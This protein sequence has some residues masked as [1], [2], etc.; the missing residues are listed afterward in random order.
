MRS[1][2]E[3][4]PRES[5]FGPTE[6]PGD[7]PD[8]RA[9]AGAQASTAQAA[10]LQPKLKAERIQNRLAAHPGWQ[11]DDGGE[12]LRR[13]FSFPSPRAAALFATL[14]IEVGEAT[15]ELPRIE[16]DHLDVTLHVRSSAGGVTERDFQLAR[17]FG[18]A[19]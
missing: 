3:S 14:A 5:R 17:R 6:W 12:G 10:S 11:V 9:V 16:I 7:G 13:R 4:I 15:G 8:G 19:P 1:D 2:D 18:L